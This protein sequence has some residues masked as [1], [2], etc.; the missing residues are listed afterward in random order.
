MGTMFCLFDSL[1]PSHVETGL[2][3]VEPVPSSG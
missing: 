1:Q 2:P 3:V